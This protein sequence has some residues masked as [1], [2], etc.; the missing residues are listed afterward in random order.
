MS[1]KPPRV[2]GRRPR[3]RRV[4][5][6]QTPRSRDSHRNRS[7]PRVAESAS[8]RTR[9]KST[10]IDCQRQRAGRLLPTERHYRRE[11][12]VSLRA[13]TM[14]NRYRP[15]RT[16]PVSAPPAGPTRATTPK[17]RPPWRASKTAP[18]SGSANVALPARVFTHAGCRRQPTNRFAAR[19]LRPQLAP[20]RRRRRLLLRAVGVQLPGLRTEPRGDHRRLPHLLLRNGALGLRD[21]PHR[22]GELRPAGADPVRHRLPSDQ[23]GHGPLVHHKRRHLLRVQA[24]AGT[25]KSCMATPTTSS[26]A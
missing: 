20:I 3:R 22:I 14:N 19:G 24:P 6:H 16:R 10:L 11:H 26:H 25:H 13:K 8:N 1:A 23:P 9:P 12:F 17:L 4:N 7:R 2:P 15:R 18:R 21:Q 5:S